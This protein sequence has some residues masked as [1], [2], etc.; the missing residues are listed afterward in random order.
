M[1]LI[2]TCREDTETDFNT[3]KWKTLW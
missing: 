1:S 3:K 2:V